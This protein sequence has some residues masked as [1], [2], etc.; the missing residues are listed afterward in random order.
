MSSSSNESLNLWCDLSGDSRV[1]YSESPFKYWVTIWFGYFETEKATENKNTHTNTG[2]KVETYGIQQRW[3]GWL[4][5]REK[6]Q[7]YWKRQRLLWHKLKVH[8]DSVLNLKFFQGL[9]IFSFCLCRPVTVTTIHRTIQTGSRKSNRKW[10]NHNEIVNI[11]I[12]NTTS[13]RIDD[14]K[15]GI[16]IPSNFFIRTTELV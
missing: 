15:T 10:R 1:M 9:S 13:K 12:V 11:R 5:R 2:V 16:K 4:E 8:E 14:S 6:S 7:V 3:T